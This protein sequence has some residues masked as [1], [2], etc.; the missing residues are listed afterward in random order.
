MSISQ[1]NTKQLIEKCLVQNQEAQLEIYNRYYKAMYNVAYR[2][3]NDAQEAED[4]MQEAFLKAFLKLDTLKESKLF[5]GW[6]KKITINLSIAALRKT[7]RFVSAPL[8]KVEHLIKE[9]N[10]VENTVFDSA[11]D[12]EAI[13]SAIS[14]LKSSYS[15][16]LTLHYIEG[17][18]YEEMAEILKLTEGNIRTLISRAKVSLRKKL[19]VI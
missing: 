19:E 1:L 15:V 10:D 7:N 4:V 9:D 12:V 6:L 14:T 18:D 11:K 16:V 5:G 17:F 3:L 13:L 2:I 8:D